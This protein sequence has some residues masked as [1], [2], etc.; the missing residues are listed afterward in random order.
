MAKWL[1]AD[2]MRNGPQEVVDNAT[3][4]IVCSQQPENREEA[5]SLYNLAEV[6]VSSADFSW[7]IGSSGQLL[8]VAA[9]QDVS[10]G[11]DGEMTHVALVDGSR[12]LVVNI[13][14]ALQLSVGNLLNL[15]SWKILVKNPA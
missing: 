10:I 8:S 6:G 11:D 7:S 12:L 3:R 9:Q 5:V 13:T 14:R 15:P 1:H 4:Y 2:V